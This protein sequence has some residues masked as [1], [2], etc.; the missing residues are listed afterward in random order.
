MYLFSGLPRSAKKRQ[1]Q[2]TEVTC[3]CVSAWASAWG[4]NHVMQEEF[5]VEGVLFS[6]L[7]HFSGT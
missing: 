4:T 5:V 3:E 6:K 1:Q 7:F 2:K